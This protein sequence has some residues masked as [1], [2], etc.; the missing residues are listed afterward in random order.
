MWAKREYEAW[1]T[2]DLDEID[3]RGK[4]ILSRAKPGHDDQWL[5]NRLISDYVPFDFTTR[6]VFNKPAF[7]ADYTNWGD[8]LK[9][10]VVERV[11]DTYLNNK[12]A[13]RTKMFGM[14]T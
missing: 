2:V 6:Y 7:Y 14:H 11:Q 13:Y 3:A 1:A 5:V 10:H 12:S 9:E 8:R 4:F